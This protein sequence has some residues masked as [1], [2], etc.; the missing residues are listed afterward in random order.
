MKRLIIAT[1][2]S[3]TALSYGVAYAAET[4][5]VCI[6]NAQGK[7][8]CKTIKK[9]KKLEVEPTKDAKKK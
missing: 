4:E 3:L 7:E 5:K 1:I 6:K 8:T 9:H 2:M